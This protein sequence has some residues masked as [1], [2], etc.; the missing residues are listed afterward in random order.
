M[1]ELP[2]KESGSF[3][4]I[5]RSRRIE[6]PLHVLPVPEASSETIAQ[7]INLPLELSRQLLAGSQV[8]PAG[9]PDAKPVYPGI[10]QQYYGPGRS[11]LVA[12]GW[13]DKPLQ[14]VPATQIVVFDSRYPPD[15]ADNTKTRDMVIYER[16]LAS[17][18][19]LQ[20]K[21]HDL[22]LATW[23]G[24]TPSAASLLFTRDTFRVKW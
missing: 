1:V 23:S 20:E 9:H 13:K 6:R 15:P 3:L 18:A 2:T 7:R 11:V 12:A 10:D 17:A 21:Y 16:V 19:Q 22:D 4:G 8:T 5:L 24:S 14:N